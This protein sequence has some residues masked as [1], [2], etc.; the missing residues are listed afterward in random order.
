MN[1]DLM[2][3]RRRLVTSSAVLVRIA[4]LCTAREGICSETQS[5]TYYSQQQNVS[6]EK[7]CGIPCGEANETNQTFPVVVALCSERKEV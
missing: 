1:S 6:K 2:S 3:V 4:A 7:R 5:C